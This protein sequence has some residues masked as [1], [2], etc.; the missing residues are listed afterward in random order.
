MIRGRM[1]MPSDVEC[2]LS[3]LPIHSPE[4]PPPHQLSPINILPPIILP[5]I[6]PKSFCPHRL[7]N[8][9]PGR[10]SFSTNQPRN[11]PSNRTHLASDGL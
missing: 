6:S 9:S 1:M 3:Q 5:P 8:S 10:S 2:S 11:A 4:P 7:A